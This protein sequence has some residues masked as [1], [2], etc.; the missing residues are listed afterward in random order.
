MGDETVPKE[1]SLLECWVEGL[2]DVRGSF[3]DE[4]RI[5]HADPER[6][7]AVLLQRLRYAAQ[8]DSLASWEDRSRAWT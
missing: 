1:L 6:H 5:Y 7:E 3:W 4:W 8:K 2:G